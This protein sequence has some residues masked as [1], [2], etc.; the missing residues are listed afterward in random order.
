MGCCRGCTVATGDT[1]EKPAIIAG[2]LLRTL[3]KSAIVIPSHEVKT[4]S[5]KKTALYDDI[6]A[7]N[8]L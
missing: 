7:Y 4:K 3:T 6:H 8:Q 2:F 5:V 1:T